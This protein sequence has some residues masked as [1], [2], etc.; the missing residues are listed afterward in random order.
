MVEDQYIHESLLYTSAQAMIFNKFCHPIAVK[1][2]A[3]QDLE[4]VSLLGKLRITVLVNSRTYYGK[5][6]LVLCGTIP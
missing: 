3:D 4:N 1:I 2:H 6:S 5:P